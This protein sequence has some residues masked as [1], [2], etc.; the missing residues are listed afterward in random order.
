MTPSALSPVSPV[1]PASPVSAIGQPVDRSIIA[2]LHLPDLS[3][4]RHTSMAYLED[5]ALANAGVFAAAGVPS[6]MLQDQTRQNGPATA[7]TVALMAALGRLLRST[8]AAIDRK[9]V[10]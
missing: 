9:S 6:L 1:S 7:A 4:A 8:Y 3:V 10:V 5:Y 2:A